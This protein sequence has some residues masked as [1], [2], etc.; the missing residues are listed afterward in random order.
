MLIDGCIFMKYI[1]LLKFDIDK[2]DKI[3]KVCNDI[4]K[5]DKTFKFRVVNEDYAV[6]MG[7]I[8]LICNSKDEC[9]RRAMWF[10][11]RV[12]NKIRYDISLEK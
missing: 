3:I 11:H 12:D 5:I 2:L 6:K 10:I 4:S 1:A 8:E 9:H 7:R